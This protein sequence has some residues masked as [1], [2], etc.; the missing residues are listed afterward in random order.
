MGG[1]NILK[2]GLAVA[3]ILL[4]IGVAFAPSINANISK[5]SIDSELVE[6]T[7]EVCG[8]NGGK[9][10]VELTQEEAAEVE[11]LFDSIRERLNNTETREEAEQIFKEAVVELDKY[12]LLGGLSVKQAQRLVTG[13]YQNSRVMKTLENLYGKNQG[14]L[15]DDANVLCLIAG[16]TSNT[17]IFGPSM[18]F[19]ILINIPI[20]I[21][22][23]L[24]A[25]LIYYMLGICCELLNIYLGVG[26]FLYIISEFFGGIAIRF[27][28]LSLAS[29]VVGFPFA[30][31]GGFIIC[32][33]RVEHIAGGYW[34]YY[35]AE[36]WVWTLGLFGI[37]EWKG[38]F[39]G[40]QFGNGYVGA[41]GFTGLRIGGSGVL[42]F[43][44]GRAYYLGSA[45]VVD[46]GEERP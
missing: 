42:R 29:H 13:G 43:P 4:F 46:I 9:Q 34:N 32:G 31:L 36:G 25:A 14:S 10:T 16:N 8:L 11:A 15:D 38:K 1:N 24:P 21:L 28:L 23:T 18:I 20:V 7:T 5:A 27:A 3:V 19:R 39:W 33:H 35:P 26:Y 17:M 12:G 6:F 40:Q 44:I 2:K 22:I 45:L 41:A 37:K 30:E